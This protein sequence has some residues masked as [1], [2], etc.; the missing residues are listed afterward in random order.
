M[1]YSEGRKKMISLRLSEEEY[2]ILRTKYRTHGARNMSDLARLAIQHIMNGP[3]DSQDG[4][5]AK[6]AAFDQRLNLLEFQ[7]TLLMEREKAVSCE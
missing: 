6:L 4:L 7:I 3:I 5:A 2:E 1:S